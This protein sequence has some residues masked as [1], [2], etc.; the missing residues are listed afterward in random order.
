M[1][2]IGKIWSAV[3]ETIKT[4]RAPKWVAEPVRRIANYVAGLAV[5][6]GALLVAGTQLTHVVPAQYQDKFTVFLAAATA[7]VAVA[8]KVAGEIARSKVFAPLTVEKIKAAA[9]TEAL[10]TP[11]VVTANTDAAE[12]PVSNIPGYGG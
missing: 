4:H 10:V 3:L 1:T 11:V 9:L 5:T 12:V 8:A 7:A 6:V 2:L